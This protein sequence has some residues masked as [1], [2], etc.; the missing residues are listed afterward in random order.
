MTVDMH[1]GAAQDS[2]AAEL[3]P[4]EATMSRNAQRSG[5]SGAA[6]TVVVLPLTH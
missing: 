2:S 3:R 4:C 5:M 1:G 6:L